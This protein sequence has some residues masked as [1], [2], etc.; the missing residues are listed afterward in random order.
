[1]SDLL[2][3]SRAVLLPYRRAASG[4]RSRYQ[5]AKN[6]GT[7]HSRQSHYLETFLTWANLGSNPL[8]QGY[9]HKSKNDV[10]ISYAMY[11]LTGQTLLA[12]SIKV[13][14]VKLY[15]KAVADFFLADEQFNP[16]L[17][18]KGGKLPT[19]ESVYHEGNRWE[20]MPNRSESLKIAISTQPLLLMQTGQSSAFMLVSE[21]QSMP[22]HTLPNICLWINRFP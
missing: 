8:L 15:L 12:K 20:K 21:F 9:S 3:E 6:I 10:I 4:C 22:R 5:S 19:L 2:S 16:T 1:M 14:T 17:D 18:Q 11:L 13:A 7:L